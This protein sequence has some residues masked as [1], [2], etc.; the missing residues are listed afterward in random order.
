MKPVHEVPALDRREVIRGVAAL[1]GGL[2]VCGPGLLSLID[3]AHSA[4][5]A[6]VGFSA[7]EI[8]FL[9]EIAD[10]ILPETST[11]GAK[12]A[13]TGAFMAIMVNESYGAA[14]RQIFRQGMQDLESTTRA[15]HGISFLQA[16]PAQRQ[17]VLTVLDAAQKHAM[18]TRDAA[19]QPMPYFRMM[20]ELALLG[21]FTSQI[22]CQQ[23]QR[24]IESPGRYDP[25]TPYSP[26]QPAWAAHA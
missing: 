26:G 24:Y 7:Q 5:A 6:P 9:D 20:K 17:S 12:A 21:Y 8:A 1:F 22:G 23:A 19:V 25:C 18:D 15:A 16:T 14:E 3:K 10:T 11:P 4:D 2:T 13:H